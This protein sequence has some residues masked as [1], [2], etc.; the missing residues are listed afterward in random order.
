MMVLASGK[1]DHFSDTC[2]SME[3][4]GLWTKVEQPQHS[5]ST[6]CKCLL[7]SM[8]QKNQQTESKSI[9]WSTELQVEGQV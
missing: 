5:F 3:D 6:L 8:K 4:G 9:G 7:P 2:Q 1:K